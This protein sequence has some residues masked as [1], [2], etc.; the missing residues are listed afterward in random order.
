M[1]QKQK[2]TPTGIAFNVTIGV[3][4]TLLIG[5]INYVDIAPWN[6]HAGS[7]WIKLFKFSLVI[8]GGLCLIGF[9]ENKLD[10]NSFL[11]D[12]PLFPLFGIATVIVLITIFAISGC[13]IFHSKQY[14]NIVKLNDT[15]AEEAVPNVSDLDSI[16]LMDTDSAR[17]LGD[18]KIGEIES[19]SAFEVASGYTQLNVNNDPVKVSPLVY[20]GFFKWKKNK[21]AGVPGYVTVSPTT[22]EA[23]YMKL[24]KGMRYV[25]SAYF[26]YNIYRKIHRDFPTAMFGWTHF[27]IDEK[28]N[29]YY[30]SAVY[31]TTVGMFSGEVVTGAIITDP[32]TGKSE[33]Y[34]LKDIPEWVDIV[35]DGDLICDLY[36]LSYKNINGYWNGTSFGA[37]TGC[38]KTTKITTS[39]DD[40]NTN[41]TSSDFGYIA[42][43]ND[44]YIYTGVTSF[45]KDNSNL[46]FIVVNSRTGEYKFFASSGA[47]EKSA[48]NAAAGE[49]QNYNYTASFPSL[50]NING[51]LSY[52]GVMKDNSG[53]V[54]M[55]YLVNA[56]DYGKVVVKATR[57]ECLSAYLTKIG[58]SKAE[59][60]ESRNDSTVTIPEIPTSKDSDKVSFT[61]S[62]IQYV[63]EDGNTYVY[64]GTEDG[65]IY[66]SLF[67][68]NE[69]L[70]FVKEGTTIS[71]TVQDGM[72]YFN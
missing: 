66:K 20:K 45:A 52:I 18:R 32:I 24:D 19:F 65:Q 9:H 51:Q 28:G 8:C 67:S 7:M 23:K 26:S 56:D 49:V 27:E 59:I 41:I 70:V 25:P 50:V 29:P 15:T 61:V 48:M 55:Y 54:K 12:K 10:K 69:E 30:V 64:I 31:K 39:S 35:W 13:Q 62:V 16:A 21:D 46:G 37:N 11:A 38:K 5:V 36:D 4:V 42:K 3:I 68:E 17:Q 33:K 58:S 44:I 2:T 1:S 34:N 71:G 60:G 72:F 14:K 40:E 47:N 6:I 57:D 53:L 22:M 43:N 63:T